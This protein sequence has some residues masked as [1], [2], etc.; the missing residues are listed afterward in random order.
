MA[1]NEQLDRLFLDRARARKLLSASQVQA[2]YMDLLLRRPAEPD[3]QAYE[4]VVERGW[5]GVEDALALLNASPSDTIADVEARV[6][7]S[8]M[9]E[10]SAGADTLDGEESRQGMVRRSSDTE[11][12]TSTLRPDD[13]NAELSPDDVAD[14][15]DDDP[16]YAEVPKFVEPLAPSYAVA[17]GGSEDSVLEMELPPPV[18]GSG[19]S[20]FEEGDSRPMPSLAADIDSEPILS[21]RTPSAVYAPFTADQQLAHLPPVDPNQTA[22][23]SITAQE[24]TAPGATASDTATGEGELAPVPVFQHRGSKGAN[25]DFASFGEDDR[26]PQV[27][28]ESETFSQEMNDSAV[29]E[30]MED[31]D[32]GYFGPPAD[33]TQTPREMLEESIAPAKPL[34]G[35]TL[36][37]SESLKEAAGVEAVAADDDSDYAATTPPAAPLASR[38]PSAPITEVKDDSD[39]DFGVTIAGQE[40]SGPPSTI[41]DDSDISLAET[42]NTSQITD[43]KI[44]TGS[45]TQF[46]TGEVARAGL[47][48]TDPSKL[49]VES[50]ITGQEMTLADLRQQMGLGDGVKLDGA[51]TG[52]AVNKLR[53]I[54]GMK[55]R[56]S[57]VREIARGG[58]GK[59]IEVEDNDLRRSVAL[60]VLRK[61]MLDR[62]DLVER[63][64]EEAQI[65][66][67]LEHPNIVPVHEIG[68]DGRGNLYFT[69]KLVEGE[70]LSSILKRMRKG[71]PGADK[72]Y[73]VARLVDIF[74]KICEGIAFAHSKGVIHRDLKPANVM[75]GRFGEVQIMDWGV[76]KIV[77]RKEDTHDRMVVSDRQQDDANRT[78]AGSILGTP[79]YMSPE[80]ARGEVNYMGPTSDIFSLGVIL[81]EL[82]A[83]KTP[84]TAQTSA[85]VLDQVKNFNP[86]PPSKMSPDRKIPPELEQLALKCIEK[87][88]H[89]RIQTVQELVDNLRSWQEGRTL[90][91][92]EYSMAQLLAKWFSRNKVAV[93]TTMAVLAALV[94]GVVVTANVARQDRLNKGR[95]SLAAADRALV[96][97]RAALAREDYDT[98]FSLGSEARTAASAAKKDLEDDPKAAEIET[99]AAIVANT[100]QQQKKSREDEIRRKERDAEKLKELEG[101]LVEARRILGVARQQDTT[102]QDPAVSNETFNDAKSAFIKAQSIDPENA[103]AK[104]ALAE[105]AD[106][107]KNYETRRRQEADLRGLRALVDD[108]G[109]KL[110]AAKAIRTDSDESY[111]QAGKSFMEAIA[112]CDSALAVAVAG[113]EGDT[114]R[115]KA[116]GFKADASLEFARRAMAL[117]RYEVADLMLNSAAGTG[118]L[119]KEVEATRV[120]L[121]KVVQEQSKFRTLV[122]DAERAANA[123]EWV[124]AQA[125]LQNAIAEARNSPFADDI[126]RA[127]LARSLELARLEG[128][129]V[130]DQ[131]AKAS[132]DMLRVLAQY[133]DLCVLLKDPD[134]LSRAE[135]LR[136]ELKLRIGKTLIAET[137][138]AEDAVAAELLEKALL[139]VTDKQDLA[140]INT[141]LTEIKLR[142]AMAR[143]SD[144][145]VLLPRGSYVVGSNR[146]GDNNPQRTIDQN[147]F[148]FIDKYL[149]TNGEYRQFVDAGGYN[150]PELWHEH[151]RPLL[152]QFVDSTGR[153]GP[154]LWAKGGY[155][156]SLDKY[157]VTGLC[158]YEA[159]AYAKW[160]GKRLPTAAEWEIAGGAAAAGQPAAGDYPFGTRDSAPAAGVLEPREVGTTEWDQ[161]SLGVRDLGCN[162]SEWTGD[163][164]GSRATIKGAEPGLRPE[165]YFRY[166]R[167]AK[168]SQANLLDRSPG[169][170][171]R[172][173]RVFTLQ[174]VTDPKDPKDG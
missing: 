126:E 130:D 151:A 134:Y 62:K 93:L 56:Y 14:L 91:A 170:G 43:P 172:C 34:S 50:N 42:G 40:D 65:T 64:L 131:R 4:V 146:D 129:R 167:R 171:F 128:L 46:A 21:E 108:A 60:K 173:V 117:M 51:G 111:Q 77:G 155:D 8:P 145:F 94:I 61:E 19:D 41:Y 152:S 160:A 103:E 123:R 168:N 124:L 16:V 114:L 69:M 1:G 90:A 147:E 132:G 15:A 55:K 125:H 7:S 84:W 101:A 44:T 83:L 107:L 127:R 156:P 166:A 110:S 136:D 120:Q 116:R 3:L 30:V 47:Q 79:S 89:K 121:A 24:W 71:D 23:P 9:L 12:F 20:L 135:M 138:G 85:Q 105:I 98:A 18:P 78:M 154:A 70:D 10:P 137:E 87:M 17:D 174:D 142:L 104:L 158:W 52:S 109:R 76:A 33:L 82:L 81:Y 13:E 75:V 57:V 157:P 53:K 133:D 6:N 32:D 49:G 63:F 165:L 112:V 106:W 59:V 97:A 5:L 27:P 144:R 25:V 35:N 22:D 140:T 2:V 38:R 99:E 72:A 92:V 163:S 162:V 96:D 66:G 139:H 148:L 169:R 122:K 39:V 68:V 164:T 119:A 153:P 113:I 29:G 74:I 149:V 141:R 161:S 115:A 48:K 118:L 36:F 100:A 54:G 88:P 11:R 143:V 95:E 26:A 73:P 159:C 28:D 102:A 58:M 80:Q 150:Q 45:K 86:E 37:D 67:Q 31:A